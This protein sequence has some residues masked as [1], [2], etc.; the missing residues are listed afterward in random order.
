MLRH[1]TDGLM[2]RLTLNVEPE[3][4]GLHTDVDEGAGSSLMEP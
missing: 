1:E 2:E 4:D 3:G